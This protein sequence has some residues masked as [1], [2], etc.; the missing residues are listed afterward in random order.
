MTPHQLSIPSPTMA[1]AWRA[2]LDQAGLGA[3][4]TFI[5]R[6]A[7]PVPPSDPGAS[8]SIWCPD[9]PVSELTEYELYGTPIG[10]PVPA[11]TALPGDPIEEATHAGRPIATVHGRTI[12]IDADLPAFFD[13]CLS[14]RE[15]VGAD[16][17][18]HGRFDLNA[19]R[20][21]AWLERPV[22][23]WW[24]RVLRVAVERAGWAFPSIAVAGNWH[25][26]LTHD[27]DHI[28]HVA[29]KPAASLEGG[30]ARKI[31]DRLG[32]GES[33]GER[34]LRVWSDLERKH[35]WRGT[36]YFLG[37]PEG[38]A[39][40]GYEVSD[41]RTS[42]AI[43]RL[44]EQGHE[45]GL[46]AS[47]DAMTDP[48]LLEGERDRIATLAGR[49]PGDGSLAGVRAHYLRYEHPTTAISHRDAGF[50]YDAS[51]GYTAATG[52]RAGTSRPF[53]AIDPR[54]GTAI[55][56]T[57]IPFAMM[58]CSYLSALKMTMDQA[59]AR[60]TEQLEEICALGGAASLLFH[61][62]RLTTDG[63][64]YDHL[65]RFCL[66]ELRRLGATVLTAEQL[67]AR[68]R[69][70]A[71][72]VATRVHAVDGRLELDFDAPDGISDIDIRAPKGWSI[73]LSESGTVVHAVMTRSGA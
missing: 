56:I 30:L 29:K 6:E 71:S 17:D 46:H 60:V 13:A 62:C 47:Y 35:G 5:A 3:F 68:H 59:R 52:Y 36:Y 34:A 54:D 48:G 16:L 73:D 43:R 42:A 38:T 18:K 24:G 32:R 51:L 12:C 27:V 40:R 37:Q 22:L 53:D 15:E 57:T 58:D 45:I 33:A 39:N 21:R 23:D 2:M 11:G 50:V 61:P 19:T 26:T 64:P 63:D 10:G 25:A 66:D 7:G 20:L 9:D 67:A 44:D 41:E 69:Q 70:V 49:T 4:A 55:G 65:F 28:D 14:R 72:I 8:P 1:R 31:S